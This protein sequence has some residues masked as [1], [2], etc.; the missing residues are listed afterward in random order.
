VRLT[1]PACAQVRELNARKM[2]E[3]EGINARVRATVSQ[4]DARILALEQQVHE[5]EGRVEQY[6]LLLHRQRCDLLS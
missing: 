2:E 1:W 5:A 3:L 6:E 4:K